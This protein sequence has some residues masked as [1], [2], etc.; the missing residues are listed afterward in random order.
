MQPCFPRRAALGRGRSLGQA[1]LAWSRD[2]G[3][4]WVAADWRSTNLEANR[5]WSAM[6]FEPSY[7]RL[8]RAI[9]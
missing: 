7:H 1:V 3:Y 5:T 9:V 2:E 8:H 6:G 4:E